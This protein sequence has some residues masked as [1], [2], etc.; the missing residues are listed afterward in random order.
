MRILFFD[1]ETTGLPKNWNA[2]V[3]DLNN[4]PRLVQLAWQVYNEDQE[5][6]EEFDFII[7]PN[8]FIIPQNASKVHKIT[9]EKAN[10]QG[11]DLIKVLE[12][13][14]KSIK[15]ANL[16]IAHNYNYDYSIMASEFLRN[17]FKNILEN[18]DFICTMKATVNF[19]K[20]S[21][22]YGYK[23]PK[24]EELFGKLFNAS[25]NAHNAL[26]DIKATARCFWKLSS[27]KVIVIPKTMNSQETK[28]SKKEVDKRDLIEPK[29]TQLLNSFQNKSAQIIIQK[30]SE[31][32]QN[33][34]NILSNSNSF[35]KISSA[36]KAEHL[37]YYYYYV[38]HLLNYTQKSYIEPKKIIGEEGSYYVFED[39]E[40]IELNDRL[41]ID[42]FT[43]LR[44]YLSSEFKMLGIYKS[45]PEINDFITKRFAL[46]KFSD[47][48]Y[49]QE[50]L[51][52]GSA[53]GRINS[54][55]IKAVYRNPLKSW[56]IVQED[57]FVKHDTGPG[58][59]IERFYESNC[60]GLD[61]ISLLL[62]LVGFEYDD[63]MK[64]YSQDT[65]S[66]TAE[67]YS[68]GIELEEKWIDSLFSS[69]SCFGISYLLD[70]E[71][72]ALSTASSKDARENVYRFL[73]K[74]KEEENYY[75]V[76]EELAPNY[77]DWWAEC[78]TT[79][80]T[81][82]NILKSNSFPG[83]TKV[84]KRQ[85]QSA[86]FLHY[87]DDRLYDFSRNTYKTSNRHKITDKIYM[88]KDVIKGGKG[89]W[90]LANI[91]FFEIQSDRLI[92]KQEI[93]LL[94]TEKFQDPKHKFEDEVGLT[95]LES[96]AAITDLLNYYTENYTHKYC[97]LYSSIIFEG[98]TKIVQEFEF[99]EF[100]NVQPNWENF[101]LDVKNI[102]RVKSFGG[103][104]EI[105]NENPLPFKD[106]NFLDICNTEST[107]GLYRVLE[108]SKEFRKNQSI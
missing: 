75:S 80:L 73:K 95:E 56:V 60:K 53:G 4:W 6:L 72:D 99:W 107:H 2:P 54:D 27:L 64:F 66:I 24:L 74:I 88:L 103:V 9:T 70:T 108:D 3:S 51:I 92:G 67:E 13:F 104:F 44:K 68:G 20:I 52:N 84:V 82:F 8:G 31:I 77:F 62:S 63:C 78:V 69:V 35:F 101:Q 29:N 81:V 25:F 86:V 76:Y 83:E 7:K 71:S 21:G 47:E 96:S 26:D 61:S 97:P 87:K 36:G 14:F 49:H 34:I 1:T 22:P 19:C 28:Y 65:K 90:Y 38:I 50:V 41:I 16:L 17:G 23:W 32:Q 11:V 59:E 105:R 10:E 39:E 12:L 100:L 85:K 43:Y 37:L 40:I 57:G 79:G 33:K 58:T 42:L 45:E 93:L 30:I 106:L 15:E 48:V 94:D 46:Y 98:Q 55:V 89:L 102:D 18:K 5:L 91:Y